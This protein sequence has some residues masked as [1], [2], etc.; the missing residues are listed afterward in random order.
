MVMLVVFS[1]VVSFGLVDAV[2]LN[3]NCSL[4]LANNVG[5][6]AIVSMPK[7]DIID[8]CHDVKEI[9]R[10]IQRLVICGNEDILQKSVD[11]CE[12]SEKNA[13]KN[14]VEICKNM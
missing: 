14:L 8:D 10:K 7:M 9:A 12:V 6:R 11:I 5:A 2:A 13:A 3:T 4:L 1:E